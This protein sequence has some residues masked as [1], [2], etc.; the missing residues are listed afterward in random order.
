[1]VWPQR[2]DNWRDGG[3]PAQKAYAALANLIAEK[4]PVTVFVQ[5]DQYQNARVKLNPTVR[6]V[7]MSSND[8]WIKDYGP[9]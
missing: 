1:M 7:E 5:E 4:Q 9:F 2:P 6:I 8:A 3:K